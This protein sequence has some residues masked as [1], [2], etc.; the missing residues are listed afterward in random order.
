MP[1]QLIIDSL[2]DLPE[3]LHDQY[4][5]N[6]EDGKFH[7]IPPEG[8]ESAS[9]VKGLKTA[10]E[11]E[12]EAAREAA[13]KL[14]AVQ[15]AN[16]GID[17]EKYEALLEKERTAEEEK[18]K[19]AG[20]WDKMRE[21][22]VSKHGEAL[23]AKDKEIQRLTQEINAIK[24]DVAVVEAISKAKGNVEL[25]KPHVLSRVKLNMDDFSVQVLEADGT[26]PK[27]DGNGNPVTIDALV[28]EM[29][30][31]KTF[32]SA[33]AGSTESGS[34]SVPQKGGEGNANAN[35][36]KPI[37]KEGL[38]RSQMTERQK[39]DYQKEYGLDALMDLPL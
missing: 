35:G 14:K 18:L 29:S 17:R 10:L 19:K 25:L 6:D 2:D 13:R 20:E 32:A 38:R 34:G 24:R 21:Q 1:L 31:S 9:D 23:S 22:M 36:G 28:G 8:F 30:S 16:S 27:V 12:R 33:F 7:L 4:K 3:M 39:I 5:K 37:Q 26:T 11:K 15:E